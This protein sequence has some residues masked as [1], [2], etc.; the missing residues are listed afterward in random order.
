MSILMNFVRK[1]A[2]K[3]ILLCYDFFEFCGVHVTPVNYCSPIVENKDLTDDL[4]K[5]KSECIGLNWN[6]VVQEQYLN[7]IF[8][9]HHN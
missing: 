9:C 1:A 7:E 8:F 5:K 3:A 4:F 2:R 6:L